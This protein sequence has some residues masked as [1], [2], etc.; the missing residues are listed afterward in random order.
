MDVPLKE[1]LEK[2]LDVFEKSINELRTNH[3]THLELR[4]EK[5]EAKM[6]R[7][8]WLLVSTLVAIVVHAVGAIIRG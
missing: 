4:V 1:Y 5:I 3:F 2:R 7:I 6:D 8:T